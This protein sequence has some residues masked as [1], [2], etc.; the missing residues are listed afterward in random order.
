LLLARS[1]GAQGEE[2]EEEAHRCLLISAGV[3]AKKTD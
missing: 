3:A 1:D 2:Q